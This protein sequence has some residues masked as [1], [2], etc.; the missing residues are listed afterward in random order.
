[1]KRKLAFVLSICLMAVLLMSCGDRSREGSGETEPPKE[2]KITKPAEPGEDDPP[3]PAEEGKTIY[4]W[5]MWSETETQ[6]EAF[7]AAISRYEADTGNKV[8][9]NW[10]GRDVR[11][12]LKTSLDGNEDI[13]VLEN[14]PDWLYPNLGTE[15]LL[16]IDDYIN[17]TYPVTG[18]KTLAET[19]MPALVN[20]AKSYASDDGVY[21]IPQ[22]PSF[23]AIFYNKDVF[24]D[25]GVTT[26]P[27][28]WDEF[29]AACEKIKAMG[30]APMTV[31]D[32]YYSLLYSQYLMMM[33]GDSW[34]AELV[35]DKT[36]EMWGD[37]AVLQ[38]ANAF[39]EMK[40]KGYFSNNTGA[41]VFP[42]GQTEVATGKTAMYLNGSWYP[43]EVADI[44]GPDFNWGV[45]AFPD[46][47]GAAEKNTKLGFISQGLAVNSKS[48][49]PDEAVGLIAY[50]M[51]EDT[52]K[53]LV[54]KASC[55]PAVEGMDWPPVLSDSKPLFDNMTG[56]FTWAGGMDTDAELT[57]LIQ[58][59]FARL[60]SG[61]FTAEQFVSEMQAKS[62]R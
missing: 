61:D 41:N 31:D 14:S 51:A 28:T 5:S 40:S 15:Y 30:V 35:A 62:Q 52:Q 18:D 54:E 9:V 25:A 39:S 44:A 58:D 43:N 24:A 11:K 12:I 33:K 20:F 1:M 10:A 29:M 17:K 48:K 55:V 8:E 47:P 57:P 53:D 36:G 42:A 34:T 13:D 45:F 27:K 21:Y 56:A 19:L 49:N 26:P 37:P 16:K 60:L 38:M 50:L 46:L 7:K 4:Y 3:E 23:A 6:A 2:P 22:Q 32:A 59:A